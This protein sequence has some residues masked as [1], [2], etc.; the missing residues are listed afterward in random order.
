MIEEI[1]TEWYEDDNERPC[2]IS[3][4]AG[5][6]KTTTA[7]LIPDILGIDAH[8]VAYMAP[9]GKA[10][11]VLE[12]S[13]TT[14]HRFLYEPMTDPRTK[15][16]IFIRKI[17][18]M[19]H[20]KLLIIDEISMVNSELLKDLK[21]LNIPI[22]GLGDPAQLKPIG[23]D[24]DILNTPDIFLTKV[25]RNDGGILHLSMHIREYEPL[26]DEYENVEFKKNIMFDLKKITGDS[27][28]ITKFNRTRKRL[29]KVYRKKVKGF[30]NLLEIGEKLMVQTNNSDSGLMNGSMLILHHI[31]DIYNGLNVASVAVED[32]FGDMRNIYI[33]LDTLKGIENSNK[34]YYNKKFG[35]YICH[36]VDYGYAIT[37]HKAQGSGFDD[38][39]IVNQGQNFEDHANWLYTAVTRA[40]K[41]VYIYEN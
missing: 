32:S 3:G 21:R 41:R 40:R 1:V 9:T 11:L 14:I 12:D 6:G 25:W 2:I 4:Y 13:A 34:T 5:C 10:A 22:V 37:C 35:Q 28:I 8:D 26:D 29:N 18:A 15:K 39:F 27:I 31:H 24:T 30:T 17:R 19:F 16:V 38:V 7:K 23:G 36:N 20:Q 33:D